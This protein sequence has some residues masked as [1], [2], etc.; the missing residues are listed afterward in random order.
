M[1]ENSKLTLDVS[2]T[3]IKK[4]ETTTAAR[5]YFEVATAKYLWTSES[6]F[7]QSITNRLS[8]SIIHNE[9][10]AK[11]HLFEKM[12]IL[13][14]LTFCFTIFLIHRAAFENPQPKRG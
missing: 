13:M 12:F 11:K 3:L 9:R 7:S 2:D 8:I 5:K 1:R 10:E 4:I 14:F 6:V